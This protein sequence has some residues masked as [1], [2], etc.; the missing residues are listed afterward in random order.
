MIFGDHE[1]KNFL[2]CFCGLPICSYSVAS[3]LWT[4]DLKVL[5]IN[6]KIIPTKKGG[7][8]VIISVGETYNKTDH[9]G[10]KSMGNVHSQIEFGVIYMTDKCKEN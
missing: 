1:I 9:H 7:H 4:I 6:L 2:N 3:Y 8:H 5:Q 10:L